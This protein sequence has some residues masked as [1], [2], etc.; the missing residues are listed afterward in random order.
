VAPESRLAVVLGDE[1]TGVGLVTDHRIAAGAQGRLDEVREHPGTARAVAVAEHDVG[2][3]R[4]LA[5]DARRG[6]RMAVDK[7]GVAEAA[8]GAVDELA[9][10]AVVGFVEALDAAQALLPPTGASA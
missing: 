9:Q 3:A 6:H 2:L 4:L 8:G 5:G 10:R 1:P 7:H